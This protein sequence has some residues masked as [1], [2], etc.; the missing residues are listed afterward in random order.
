[1]RIYHDDKCGYRNYHLTVYREVWDAKA[2]DFIWTMVLTALVLVCCCQCSY[3]SLKVDE[4][5]DLDVKNM[6]EG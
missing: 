3:I 5:A 1:M 4:A 2:H 6:D